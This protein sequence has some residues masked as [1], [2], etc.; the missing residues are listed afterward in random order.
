MNPFLY[1][2]ASADPT[3]FNDVTEGD[4]LCTR[5]ACCNTGFT[6]AP[7]WGELQLKHI[8]CLFIL[9]TR[10]PCLFREGSLRFIAAYDCD[11]LVCVLPR[12]HL[13]SIS[14]SLHECGVSLMVNGH[15]SASLR[16]S[17]AV[18]GLGTPNFRKMWRALKVV[19]NIPN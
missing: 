4:N 13:D 2:L 11:E 16:C 9:V 3:A 7:G 15:L 18:T 8:V 19:H 12:S 6:A 1:S 14:L 17:D 10:F 5:F